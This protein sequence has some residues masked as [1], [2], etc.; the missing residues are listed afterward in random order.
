MLE[1][2]TVNQFKTDTVHLYPLISLL[3]TIHMFFQKEKNRYMYM[4]YEQY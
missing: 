2:T 4:Y 3:N 1:F